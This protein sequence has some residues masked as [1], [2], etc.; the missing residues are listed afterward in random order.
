[1]TRN[2]SAH[3]EYFGTSQGIVVLEYFPWVV[4]GEN[5]RPHSR[6][7]WPPIGEAL[8]DGWGDVCIR[9]DGVTNTYVCNFASEIPGIPTPPV[10]TCILFVLV[11]FDTAFN[12]AYVEYVLAQICLDVCVQLAAMKHRDSLV[13]P[14]CR[15]RLI[16]SMYR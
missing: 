12:R 3:I 15:Q 14:P 9:M 2:P 7:L 13:L 1:M 5:V 11:D 8:G 6:F 16:S 4:T 10:A